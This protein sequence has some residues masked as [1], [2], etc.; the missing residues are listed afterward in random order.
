MFGSKRIKALEAELE[1]QKEWV[2]VLEDLLE[3]GH[4][5]IDQ[6]DVIV[7]KQRAEIDD[8]YQKT[9]LPRG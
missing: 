8:L 5:R 1:K 9:S 7:D 2:R 4:K 3:M 6:L